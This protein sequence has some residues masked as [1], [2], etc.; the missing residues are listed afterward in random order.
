MI[1]ANLL[2]ALYRMSDSDSDSD[3]E[4]RLAAVSCYPPTEI[5]AFNQSVLFCMSMKKTFFS[6][7]RRCLLKE[8]V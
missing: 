8:I 3:F 6:P 4:E 1:Y 7:L 5:T 2:T